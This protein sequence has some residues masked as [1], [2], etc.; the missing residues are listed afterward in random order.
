M[1]A[2]STDDATLADGAAGHA[3]VHAYSASVSPGRR[4]DGIASRELDRA[5][6]AVAS[7]A[8]TPSLYA[9][10]LG[11]AWTAQLLSGAGMD[12][13]EDANEE[14]GAGLLAVVGVAPWPGAYGLI[15]GLV[16][17]GVYALERLPRAAG[18]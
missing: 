16:G 14:I 13:A 1:I 5:I 11:V 4:T 6:D 10:F 2:R 17:F 7:T 12:S 3:L 15:S 8:M 18:W 9:G